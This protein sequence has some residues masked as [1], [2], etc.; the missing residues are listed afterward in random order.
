M[1]LAA[2]VLL[3]TLVAC[4][5]FRSR[6]PGHPCRAINHLS[7]SLSPRRDQRPLTSRPARPTSPAMGL[8]FIPVGDRSEA[9]FCRVTGAV[10]LSDRPNQLDASLSP[11]N[12]KM[13]CPLAAE[14]ATWRREDVEPAAREKLCA[15]VRRIDHLGVYACRNVNNQVDGRPSAHARAAAMMCGLPPER[16]SADH[17]A[18]DCTATGRRPVPASDTRPSLQRLRHNPVARLQRCPLKSLAPGSR[19]RPLLPLTAESRKATYTSS[20]PRPAWVAAER[21]RTKPLP[22]HG[23]AASRRVLGV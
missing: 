5:H 3:G 6:I 2:S 23:W 22:R 14:V 11:A 13:A 17:V 8:S 16:W 7:V 9:A 21:P 19:Y 10:V 12:P 15:D 4:A 18:G 1:P 20:D